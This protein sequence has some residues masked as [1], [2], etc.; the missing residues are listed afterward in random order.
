MM[1]V[2]SLL[3][4]HLRKWGVTHVFGIPGKSISPLMLECEARGIEFVLTRHEAGAG[5]MAGG[6]AMTH[7][8]LGV[9]IGTS[10]PGG[11]NMLTAAGQAKAYN[12]PVLFITGQPSIRDSG[13]ALGQDSSPFTTDLVKM[14]EPVTVFSA[15]IEREDLVARYLQHA[16]E[17]AL[18]GVRGPVHLC[19]PFD[20]LMAD[21]EPFDL[22]LPES[23]RRVVSPDVEAVIPL[24]EQAQRPVL[25]IGKGVLAAEACDEVR[26]VAERWRIPVICTPGG[27]G[28]F[29]TR[30]PLCLGNFGLGGTEQARSYLKSGVDLM[31]A[32]G[33]KLS[34]MTL[35]GFTEDMAPKQ[36]VHFDYDLTFVGKSIAAPTLA[37]PGD[38]KLNL[39]MLIQKAGASRVQAPDEIGIP[40]TNEAAYIAASTAPVEAGTS[41]TAASA[42][43][44]SCMSA[45]TAVQALRKALPDDAVLFGDDG[46]HSFYAIR[47][48]D[49]REA[50]TFY[51]DDVFGAMGHAIGYSIGASIGAP[52][53]PI[54]CLTGDGCAMMHG[55]EISTAVNHQVPVI[56]VVLNNGRLDMVDKGMSYLTGRSVG[57]IYAHPLDVVQYAQSMGA[58]AHCCR[59]E[60]DIISSVQEA[61]GTRK[62]AVIEVMVDPLEIPPILTRLLSL[63]DEQG[64]DAQGGE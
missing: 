28:A 25:F 23:H 63:D 59:T 57:A 26:A 20:I 58:D 5:F 6:Y 21:I 32:I 30:H 46:S 44:G 1:K 42:D 15:R 22:P 12:M 62:P 64:E 53:K 24:L 13:K 41:Q 8:T 47:H 10:G 51:F 56:I 45:V 4:E 54:V 40:F 19:I 52:D 37:I 18:T 39:Q 49:I 29:P 27:K 60:A 17:Q 9:A 33:T 55:N 31:L 34:D 16:V 11:T 48:Y 35:S 3:V 43:T 61:L 38:A 36:I 7:Q 2:Y 14:F 50:G